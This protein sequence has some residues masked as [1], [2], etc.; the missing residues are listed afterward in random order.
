MIRMKNWSSFA[1]NVKRILEIKWKRKTL[2]FDFFRGRK[3]FVN[4]SQF[5][6]N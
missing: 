5:V 1:P 6:S 3:K 2:S 4:F